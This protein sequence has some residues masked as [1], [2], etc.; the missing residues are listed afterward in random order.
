MKFNFP[1]TCINLKKYLNVFKLI[2]KCKN[3]SHIY[4]YMN[5]L[6]RPYVF[7]LDNKIL[8]F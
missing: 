1:D 3:E 8:P 5:D 6:Y 2:R 7:G 4:V